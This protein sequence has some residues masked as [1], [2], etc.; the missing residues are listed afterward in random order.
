MS[1]N[2]ERIL[3]A[4]N[5]KV[6][7]TQRVLE[8]NPEHPMVRNLARLQGEGKEGIEPLARLLLDYANIA[9][10]RLEDAPGF[11]KR[12]QSLLEKASAAM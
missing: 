6:G 11:T 7:A 12:L 10:G 9:E 8:I 2:L 1:A 5:Q 3:R 4:A